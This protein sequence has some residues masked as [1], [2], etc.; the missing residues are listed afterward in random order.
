MTKRK[1]S[2]R[3]IKTSWGIA[4]DIIAECASKNKFP[5]DSENSIVSIVPGLWGVILDKRLPNND[6][7]FIWKGL[8]NI[9]QLILSNSTYKDDTLIIIHSIDFNFCDYQPE[10]LTPAIIGW[11]ANSLGFAEPLI[12]AL[13]DSNE[14]KYNFIIK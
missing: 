13:F 2:F 6:I 4:I 12:E 1:Y 9:S 10:G 14:N 11:A 8:K 5:S 7:Q 3:T